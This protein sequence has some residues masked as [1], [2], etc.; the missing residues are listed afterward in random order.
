MKKI[1]VFFLLFFSLSTFV[2]A[3]EL[4]A[5]VTIDAEQTGKTQL[6]IFKTLETAI[7]DFINNNSWTDLD[8]EEREKINCNF[9]IRVKSYE[10][11]DFNAS[12]QIQSSRPIYGST[13][14]TPV[15]NYKDDAFGFSYSEFEPL[16]YTPNSFESNLVS[17]ISF[18]VYTILGL[19]ADTFAPE[20]GTPY[21]QEARRIVNT[22][23]GNNI[24]SWESASG[25]NSKSRYNLNDALLSSNFSDFRQAMYLYHRKGLD[26]MHKDVKEGKENIIQAISLLNKVNSVRPN[27]FL[28]RTFFDAK[29]NEIE[30]ILSGGPS[31][32]LKEVVN[33]LNNMAP[34][35]S[36]NWKNISY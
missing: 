8:L 17:T 34:T 15:M 27:S 20:G 23:Q 33:N 12:L 18:Y 9:F 13:T 10:S 32:S 14:S 2:D 16:D 25:G 22:A 31:V 26:V 24:P 35:H 6:S 3:Q 11:G 36:D 1:T 4:E 28:L 5:S 30:Q 7:E 19:D 21:F 29:A